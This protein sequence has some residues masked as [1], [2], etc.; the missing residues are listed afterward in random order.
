MPIEVPILEQ[1]IKL[2]QKGQAFPCKISNFLSVDFLYIYIDAIRIFY[3]VPSTQSRN[4]V[5]RG[6]KSLEIAWFN[7][8]MFCGQTF[9]ESYGGLDVLIW[10]QKLN[11][12][13]NTDSQSRE[14]MCRCRY[15]C[16]TVWS[17]CISC[18]TLPTLVPDVVGN[19]CWTSSWEEAISDIWWLEIIP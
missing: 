6:C 13:L 14:G 9:V 16:T 1:L 2:S 8:F 12:R 11:G 5:L 7:P 10:I 18:K 15:T 4:T 3:T 19:I 17:T